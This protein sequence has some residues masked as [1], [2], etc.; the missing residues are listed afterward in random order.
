[1]EQE[2]RHMVK[3]IDEILEILVVSDIDELEKN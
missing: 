3:V 1:M 2:L